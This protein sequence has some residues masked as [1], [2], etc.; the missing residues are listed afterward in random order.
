MRIKGVL[1][2]IIVPLAASAQSAARIAP[3]PGDPLEL[4]AGQIPVEAT[5]GSRA[6]FVKLLDRARNNY[7]LRQAKRGYDLK[8][9]FG[10]DS[11]GQ[12][13]YDGAWDL[14][15]LFVPG[16]GLHWTAKTAA[17][18]NITGIASSG[19]QYAESSAPTIPLRLEEARGILLHP[20]PSASYVNHESIRTAAASINGTPVTCIL[21]STSRAAIPPVGRAWEES[22]ECIDPLT[23]LLQ[24][25]SEAPGRYVV[26]DYSDAPELAGHVLPRTV[27]VTEGGRVVSKINIDKLDGIPSAD[28]SLFTPTARMQTEGRATEM[29]SAT[30][31]SRS[32]RRLAPGVTVRPVCVFGVVTS[33]GQL[34]E[35]HSLQPSDPNS[36]AAIDDAK[37]IDFSGSTQTGQHFVFIIEKFASQ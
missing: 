33:A 1:A 20:L 16:Q 15:D 34:V 28:A 23:G 18:F 19:K 36:Q 4:V 11:R 21:L 8:I 24:L 30:K 22:E 37:Q 5:A 10:V 27:T 6:S 12:T 35:A 26:Y 17:G 14:E 32:P 3:V 2:L 13:A 25:H 31:V 29:T 7:E 9:S